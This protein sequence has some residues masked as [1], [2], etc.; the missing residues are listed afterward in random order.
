MRRTS[1][2]CGVLLLGCISSQAQTAPAPQKPPVKSQPGSAAASEETKISP[3]KEADIR[4]LLALLGTTASME[5]TMQSMEKNIRPMM[6]NSLPPGDYQERLLTLFFEKFHSKMDTQKLTDLAV[7]LY[8]KY[9]THEDIKGL[10]QFYQ[11]PLGRKTVKVLPSLMGELTEAGQ[12][13]GQVIAR[14]S[15]MEV[16]AEH[17]EIEKAMEDAQAQK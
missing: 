6:A 3:A 10:I 2:L 17:P 16:I 14:Q 5:Q 4:K 9:Y 7:P 8:D 11:T 13:M 15:M 1:L 12:S